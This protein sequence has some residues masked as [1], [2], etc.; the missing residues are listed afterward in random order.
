MEKGLTIRAIDAALSIIVSPFRDR[1]W[2]GA[3]Q[4]R[5]T[6][7]E[8]SEKNLARDLDRSGAWISSGPSLAPS[9]ASVYCCMV[10]GSSR[11]VP[12]GAIELVRHCRWI[13]LS[14]RQLSR[15]V[16]PRSNGFHPCL[17]FSVA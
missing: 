3:P 17:C 11:Q 7:L 12:H 10:G 8:R 14:C 2:I 13:M 1:T 4:P 5:I 9:R 6:Q 16:V 15:D